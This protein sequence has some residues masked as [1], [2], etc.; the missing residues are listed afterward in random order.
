MWQGIKQLLASLKEAVGLGRR[1][2]GARA[3]THRCV[4]GA[5]WRDARFCDVRVGRLQWQLWAGSCV[6]TQCM[7]HF[8][9]IFLLHTRCVPGVEPEC[10]WAR[11]A[12]R[13]CA[14]A[15]SGRVTGPC[16]PAPQR[17]FLQLFRRARLPADSERA[18]AQG[19]PKSPT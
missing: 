10:T 7:R 12:A 8:G 9:P 11:L 15:L 2:S 13:S 5:V 16:G 3:H 18:A 4:E 14:V 19:T 1:S 6:C 17:V